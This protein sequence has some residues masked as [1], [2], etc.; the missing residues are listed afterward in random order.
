MDDSAFILKAS[1][2]FILSY[3]Y[4]ECSRVTVTESLRQKL[5]FNMVYR[6]VC[7]VAV[8]VIATRLEGN[9]SSTDSHINQIYREGKRKEETKELR[10]ITAKCV[11]RGF[12]QRII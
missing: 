8:K 4:V 11:R 10:I 1:F 9:P 12:S 6:I 2:P 7:I 5:K 3:V